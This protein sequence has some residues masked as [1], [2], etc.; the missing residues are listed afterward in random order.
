[1]KAEG[2]RLRF[3]GRPVSVEGLACRQVLLHQMP[4]W[5]GTST[6][7]L[8]G[9]TLILLEAVLNPAPVNIKIEDLDPDAKAAISDE[10]ERRMRS[11]AA[12]L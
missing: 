3:R 5:L 7:A 1:M 10:I 2:R 9:G 12:G 11:I 4:E 8:E 6:R